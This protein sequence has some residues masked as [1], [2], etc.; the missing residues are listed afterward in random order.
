[1]QNVGAQPSPDF[2]IRLDGDIKPWL[3]PMRSLSRILSAVQRLVDQRDDLEDVEPEKP[4]ESI[5][6]TVQ[7]NRTLQ[8][9]TIKAGSANYAVSS[10]NKFATLA[11]LHETGKSIE[12]PE[13]A[14]WHPA[15]IS[16]LDELSHMASQLGVVIEI[17]S[18]GK[19]K[20][21]GD[22][23]AK[24]RPET[25]SDVRGRAF[26]T[27]HTSVVGELQGVG[28][29]TEM[30]CRI[31]VRGRNRLLYCGVASNQLIREMGMFIYA[32]VLLS[33]NAIWYKSNNQLKTLTVTSFSPTKTGSLTDVAKRI[34]KAGGDVWD[35]IADPDAY[36]R[37]M[38]GN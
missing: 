4:G 8:L 15:T 25:A 20:T 37:E 21:L 30:K 18:P 28:G 26:R 33:G 16:S 19:G 2:V 14:L 9:L 13:R 29:A 36:I 5:E 17:R 32:D 12:A 24:I 10:E 34:R 38:R 3:V 6:D 22:V 1:M 31:R 27:G 7:A 35:R 11:V 23:I